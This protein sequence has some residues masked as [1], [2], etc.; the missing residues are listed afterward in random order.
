MKTKL[1]THEDVSRRMEIQGSS[2][3]GFGLVFAGFFLLVGLWPL[4]QGRG[5][6]PWALGIATIFGVLALTRPATL[7]PLNRWWQRFGLLVHALVSPVV[8]GLLFYFTITPIGLL[9]RLFGKDVVRLRFE[10]DATSYWIQRRPPGPAPRT[11]IN[12][13]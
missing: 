9:L 8:L 3:R 13:F 4:L 2:D 11:M 5:V 7:A 6:R 10:P 12:Q 1:V